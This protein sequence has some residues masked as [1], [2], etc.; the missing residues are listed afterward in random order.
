MADY[1]SR[2]E[3]RNAQKNSKTKNKKK[4]KGSLFK[5]ILLTVFI[6]GL[7]G[8]L[9]GGG[10]FAYYASQAPDLNEEDF[11]DPITTELRDVNGDVFAR[12]GAENREFVSYDEIPPLVE[13]AVLAIEDNRFYEHQG[14]DFFRLMGAVLANITEGFGAEGASTLTQQV[15]KQSVLTP[16]KSLERKA[17]EAWLAYQLEQDYSKEDI[18]EMYVNKIYYSDSIYGIRTAS[19]YYYDVDLSDLKLHQAAL[20]AGLPQR[21]NAYNPYENP[22]LAKE[23]RDTVLR[24]MHNHG[25]ISEEEMTQAIETDITDGLVDRSEESGNPRQQLAAEE[26]KYD[27]FVD[28]VLDELEALEDVNPYED[29]LKI[30]TTLDPNAQTI[31]ENTLNDGSIQFPADMN[32]VM[33]QAGV[34]LLDTESGAIRAIGG[35]RGY[36]EEVQRG[37]NYATDQ[38]RQPGSA[39]K[40]LLDYAPAIEY[41]DW[42]TAQTIVDEPYEYSNGFEPNNYDGQ[43]KGPMTM[44]DALADSRNI[45]AIKAYM[46]VGQEQGTEFLRGLGWDFN[47]ENCGEVLCES[48]AIGGEP[49]TNTL[50]MAGAYAAFGNKGVYNEPHSVTSIEF[51]DGS[52]M[53]LEA[54]SEVAMKDSTAYMM[55]DMLKDVLE[56]GA[57]GELAQVDGLPLAGK[58]GTTNYPE[59]ILNAN[60]IPSNGAP[61]SWFAGFTSQYTA[62]VWL[63]YA[64]NQNENYLSPQDR[65]VSQYIFRDIMRGV[66][67][68]IETPDFE[69]PDS[70]V[71]LEIEKGTS[72]VQLASEY[73]PDDQKSVE[74]FIRGTEPTSVSEEYVVPD[75]EAPSNL[76]AEYNDEDGTI[77]LTWDHNQDENDD[78][79]V[80]FEV[81]VSIDGGEERELAVTSQNGLNIEQVQEGSSYTFTVTAIADEERSSSANTNIEIARSEDE[82]QDEEDTEEQNEEEQENPEDNQEEQNPEEGNNEGEGEGQGQGEGNGEGQGNGNDESNTDEGSGEQEPA[83]EEENTGDENPEEPAEGS[84]DGDTTDAE[85]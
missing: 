18:F 76:S 61:D 48:A 22:E 50:E 60:G 54:E 32:D 3:K 68:G 8:L 5:K 51:R 77:Q 65:Y 30:N 9:F 56:P 21:P 62:A 37:F 55:A 73:T 33:A 83:Q 39:I 1:K 49:E 24:Q 16:E 27:A 25:K 20:L 74:L 58:S 64:S 44:R 63:G 67:E 15:I 38:T 34:T 2:E 35:G 41:L 70:V 17:Q 42:S 82:E 78:R 14:V 80:E 84:P 40:P 85:Q 13:N 45:T 10:L 7:A 71:E 53:E 23:R 12:I 31:V 72:P 4:K 43:F 75:L 19:Q 28:V 66:H 26:S 79:D 57:T 29:G 6:V 52:S 81:L 11:I 59:D 36:G 46:E 69:K 47:T